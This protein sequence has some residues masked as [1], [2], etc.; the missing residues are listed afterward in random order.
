MN[1]KRLPANLADRVRV[2]EQDREHGALELAGF[3]VDAIEAALQQ[4]EALAALR[5]AL[6]DARPTMV[7]IAGA[8]RCCFEGDPHG[9]VAE[10]RRIIRDGHARVAKHLVERVGPG[11]RIVTLSRSSAVEAA[12]KEVTG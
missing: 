12:V 8:V 9:R 3:A 7:A 6:L 2:I 10:A 4:P 11:R 5:D 1:E